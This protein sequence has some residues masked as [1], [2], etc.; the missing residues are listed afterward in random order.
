MDNLSVADR[1]LLSGLQRL[2][3]DVT[4][5]LEHYRLSETGERLYGFVWD[6]FCD[7]YLELSKG[8]SNPVVLIHALR[9]I[10]HL[11]HPYCPFVTEE[12]WASIAPAGAGSLIRGSFPVVEKKLIDHAAEAQLQLLIDVITAVRSLR[13]EYGVSPDAKIPVTVHVA[14]TGEFLLA[15]QSHILRLANVSAC[16]VVTKAPPHKRGTVSAF[17]KGV[18][19]HLSLEGVVDLEKVKTNLKEERVQL[20]KFLAGVHAKLENEQFIARAKPEVVETEKQKLADGEAKLKKI[21]ERLKA[22]A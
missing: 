14:S 6:Y 10:V 16:E 13:A 17:L 8:E 15:H 22:L 20:Q 9:T 18:D 5:G 12:I 3:A 21:E 7:W 1:A 4:D 11:L 19:I 2:I